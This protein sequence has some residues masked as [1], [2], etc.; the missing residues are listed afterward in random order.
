[1]RHV[2]AALLALSILPAAAPAFAADS[3][4]LAPNTPVPVESTESPQAA[5][6]PAIRA[7]AATISEWDTN[8]SID[9][10]PVIDV[11]Q[12]LG[13]GKT[14]QADTLAGPTAFSYSQTIDQKVVDQ[15]LSINPSDPFGFFSTIIDA[16]D[17]EWPLGTILEGRFHFPQAFNVGGISMVP[18]ISLMQD[19]DEL[20]AHIRNGIGTGLEFPLDKNTNFTVEVLYLDHSGD[21]NP[22]LGNETR[23][24][25][26]FNFRF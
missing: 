11:P 4:L 25:A 14:I 17:S 20:D 8:L 13:I 10:L 24:M 5:P 2:T 21:V 19:A 18:F 22:V 23:G 6:K 26:L 12:P 15:V 16:D 1:M 9:S 7:T 3:A